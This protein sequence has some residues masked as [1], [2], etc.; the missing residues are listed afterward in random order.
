M[1]L[2]SSVCVCVILL[3][4]KQIRF[5]PVI[6][7]LEMDHPVHWACISVSYSSGRLAC[8]PPQVTYS[9]QELFGPLYLSFSIVNML[10]DRWYPSMTHKSHALSN[11]SG[12]IGFFSPQDTRCWAPGTA[13]HFPKTTYQQ[14]RFLRLSRTWQKCS[15]TCPGWRC[16]VCWIS[17]CTLALRVYPQFSIFCKLQLKRM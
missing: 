13:G 16:P 8:L 17:S 4:L 14:C 5:V 12:I 11:A 9:T 3:T 7:L 6:R 1:T 10:L 15:G 2:C